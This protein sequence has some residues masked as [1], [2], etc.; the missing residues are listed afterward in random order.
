M[1]AVLPVGDVIH[2]AN[3]L[4]G[5]TPRHMASAAARWATAAMRHPFVL[6]SEILDWSSEEAQVLAGTSDVDP[7]P[8]F[9]DPAS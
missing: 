9:F 4:V 8:R 5:M 3:P 7:D 6:A 2:G 1:D